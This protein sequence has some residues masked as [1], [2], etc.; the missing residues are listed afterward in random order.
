MRSCWI[1][2]DW[3]TSRRPEELSPDG[4]SGGEVEERRPPQPVMRHPVSAQRQ[5]VLEHR[6]VFLVLSDVQVVDRDT[7]DHVPVVGHLEP[8]GGY[9]VGLCDQ[10]DI[11]AGQRQLQGRKAGVMRD[12]PQ[13]RL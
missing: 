12:L 1:W 6:L 11:A 5:D 2:R 3:E 7:A 8:F 9:A 4:A 13:R 10:K